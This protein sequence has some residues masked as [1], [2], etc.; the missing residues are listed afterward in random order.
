MSVVGKFRTKAMETVR[1]P[2]FEVLRCL[3]FLGWTRGHLTM[4]EWSLVQI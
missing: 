2:R 1:S 4:P 3:H